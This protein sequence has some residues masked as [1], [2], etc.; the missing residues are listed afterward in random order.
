[1]FQL[2]QKRHSGRD[3]RNPEATDGNAKSPP[4]ELDIDN[5][6]R[7]DSVAEASC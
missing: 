2:T 1:M 3:C 6:C 5:P 4:C 7:Y